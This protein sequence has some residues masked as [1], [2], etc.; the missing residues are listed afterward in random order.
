MAN[1]EIYWPWLVKNNMKIQYILTIIFFTCVPILSS[2]SEDMVVNENTSSVTSFINISA[3]SG[4]NLT[5]K[6][7]ASKAKVDIDIETV[8]NGEKVVDESIEKE[9]GSVEIDLNI[10]TKDTELSKYELDIKSETS[11]DIQEKNN[12]EVSPIKADT[13]TDKPL[14]E[15]FLVK[16]VVVEFDSDMEAEGIKVEAESSQEEIQASIVEGVCEKTCAEENIETSRQEQNDSNINI[17]VVI[18]NYFVNIFAKVFKVF[19]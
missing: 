11:E 19:T 8:V 1:K 17:F 6:E 16:E 15:V 3:N 4:A 10:E 7:E 12:A 9:G 14:E 2:A 18:A 13:E 5:S